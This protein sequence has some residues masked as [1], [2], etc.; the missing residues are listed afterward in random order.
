MTA[1]PVRAAVEEA[2]DCYDQL[3]A[4]IGS[5]GVCGVLAIFAWPMLLGRV[6]VRDDLGNYTLIGRAFFRESL[7]SGNDFV[8]WPHLDG[9]VFLH[10][11]GQLGLYHP[12]R[13][14]VYRVLPLP[15]S[16]SIELFLSYPLMLIG[17]LWLLRR[18]RFSPAASLFGA[19]LITF[20][21]FTL[22]HHVHTNVVAV[23]AHIPWLLV[24]LDILLGDDAPRRRVWALLGVTL[25]TGSQILLHFP[26]VLVMSLQVELFYALAIGLSRGTLR[27]ALPGL[28]A[29]KAL[30]LL[31]GAVQLLP[32]WDY[33]QYTV[34][35]ETTLAFR[36]T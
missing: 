33:L 10:G 27:R 13:Y 20:S 22:L 4:R 5:L 6:F 18:W 19:S 14:L 8:W 25:L 26:Q 15:W 1:A 17:A 23:A 16:F 36:S 12:F 11:L 32:S 35:A 9:G 28:A 21:G 24:M 30:A 7:L 3:L 2:R 31:L 29:A 34:R